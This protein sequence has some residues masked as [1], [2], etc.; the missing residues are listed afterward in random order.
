MMLWIF[1]L[2]SSFAESEQL[3]GQY[4]HAKAETALIEFLEAKEFS[5]P[6]AIQDDKI[7]C[8]GVEDFAPTLDAIRGKLKR[9]SVI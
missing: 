2:T 3:I 4:F 8:V 1:L 5:I 7:N 6:N 9:H